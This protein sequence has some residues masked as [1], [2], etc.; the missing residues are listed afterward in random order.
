MRPRRL[1][2]PPKTHDRLVRLCK[3]A[4]RDG[5]Y[6][7]AKRLQAVIP[8]SEAHMQRRVGRNPESTQ[9]EGFG[10]VAAL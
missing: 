9:I 3:E 6:R 1:R 10:V 8:N 7:V 5:A 4:E 2:L